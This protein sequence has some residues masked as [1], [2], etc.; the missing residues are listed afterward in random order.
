MPNMKARNYTGAPRG[1]NLNARWILEGAVDSSSEP[2]SDDQ[3]LTLALLAGIVH[4]DSGVLKS[5]VVGDSLRGELTRLSTA[6]YPLRCRL[7]RQ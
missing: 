6:I 7:S 3:V 4:R 1:Y 5:M 2:D